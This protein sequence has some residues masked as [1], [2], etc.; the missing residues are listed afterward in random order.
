MNRTLFIG[1]DGLSPP[2]GLSIH[3]QARWW[4]KHPAELEFALS[5]GT[6]T[7]EVWE[8]C[9]QVGKDVDLAMKIADRNKVTGLDLEER[10]RL[11]FLLTDGGE[12]EKPSRG[13]PSKA[14][15]D[16][17]IAYALREI[18]DPQARVKALHDAVVADSGVM[19]EDSIYRRIKRIEKL[20]SKVKHF[21]LETINLFLIN[22]KNEDDF[23]IE[24]IIRLLELFAYIQDQCRTQNRK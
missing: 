1:S 21:K 10:K 19:E 7:P 17:R 22:S 4:S 16:L 8:E 20:W 11:F 3:E 6:I 13:R 14:L 2:E 18:S 5:Q 9:L 24:L 15:P 12:L 23:S